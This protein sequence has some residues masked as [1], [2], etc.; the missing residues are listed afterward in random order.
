MTTKQK[1]VFSRQLFVLQLF[2]KGMLQFTKFAP[3][4]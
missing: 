2:R 3:L 1:A 4:L